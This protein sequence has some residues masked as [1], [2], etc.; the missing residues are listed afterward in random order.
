M[1]AQRMEGSGDRASARVPTSGVLLVF[2]ILA[3]A[4][5]GSGDDNGGGGGGAAGTEGGTG[6]TGILRTSGGAGGTT[7]VGSGGIGIAGGAACDCN[8]VCNGFASPGEC[9][10]VQC[11]CP[12]INCACDAICRGETSGTGCPQSDCDCTPPVNDCAPSGDALWC[13]TQEEY[14]A[15]QCDGVALACPVDG[16]CLGI[17]GDCDCGAD[18]CDLGLPIGGSVCT[19]TVAGGKC[20]DRAEDACACAGCTL[21]HCT[22]AESEPPIAMCN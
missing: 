22:F 7:I 4:C 21:D 14:C 10:G 8:R 17:L 12:P 1:E 6:G 15:S 20:F 5:F 2:C 18:P 9:A 13:P 11:E 16:T 19:G 3:Q